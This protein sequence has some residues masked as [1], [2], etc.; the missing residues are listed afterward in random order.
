MLGAALE[1]D[2]VPA[3]HLKPAGYNPRRMPEDQR[4]LLRKG[5]EEFGIVDPIIANRTTGNVVG[6]HQRLDLALEMGIKL[7]PV[8]WVELDEVKEKAL[9]LALNKISGEWDQVKL[10]QV[11]EDITFADIDAELSGFAQSETDEILAWKPTDEEPLE[12]EVPPEPPKPNLR[13][14][15]VFD[16]EQQHDAW[17][18]FLAH[19]KDR[20]P[21]FETVGS[22][23]ERFIHDQRIK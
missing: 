21:E 23:L 10:R 11:I 19:I 4:R 20:Y 9:N 16:D 14:G 13:Y 1:I 12:E 3:S 8:I 6:G 15:L 2:Y 17:V 22:R 5:F 7:V 18:A